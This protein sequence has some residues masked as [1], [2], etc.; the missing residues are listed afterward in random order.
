MTKFK[1]ATI[2]LA[3]AGLIV[4]FANVNAKEKNFDPVDESADQITIALPDFPAEKA[5]A[6]GIKPGTLE[7]TL[8]IHR[9][10]NDDQKTKPATSSSNCYK[11]MGISWGKTTSYVIDDALL[12]YQ[13][14]INRSVQEWDSN[15]SKMLFSGSQIVSDANWDYYTGPDGRNEYSFGNY[16]QDGV[17]AVAAVWRGVPWNRTSKQ[18]IEY[19]VMFDVDFTWGNADTNPALMDIQNISTH[20]TG[21][22]LG[23]SDIYSTSCNEVTMYGYSTNGETKKRSLEY[24]DKLGLWRLYGN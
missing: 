1:Y 3:C 22:G 9:A 7:K 18:I 21:H 16:P 14:A 8:F 6:L 24:A 23:L 4:C 11:L 2:F 17:I 13:D 20:E 10:K 12:S 15:T 5:K 19:D